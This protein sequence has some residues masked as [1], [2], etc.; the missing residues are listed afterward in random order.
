MKQVLRTLAL[1]C[2]MLLLVGGVSFATSTVE[3]WGPFTFYSNSERSLVTQQKT[4]NYA[5]ANAS[6][7][8]GTA[9]SLW[10]NVKYNG[11][12]VATTQKIYNDGQVN[13]VYMLITTMGKALQVRLWGA[14]Q[15]LSV[16][17]LVDTADSIDA[18]GKE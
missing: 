14:K 1:L 12:D 6:L 15:G 18:Y 10:V 17:R 16:R 4:T 3:S 5:Y 9:N 7:D 2:A 11:K 13:R 8:N